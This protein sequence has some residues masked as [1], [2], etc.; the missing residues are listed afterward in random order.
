MLAHHRRRWASIETALGQW[1][2]VAGMAPRVLNLEPI[3]SLGNL[4][5]QFDYWQNRFNLMKAS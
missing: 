5:D 2:V 4:F 3:I 1:L